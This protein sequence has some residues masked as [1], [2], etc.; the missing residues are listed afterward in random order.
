MTSSGR[1][2]PFCVIV[3]T[4]KNN[5]AVLSAYGLACRI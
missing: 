4:V 5:T 3:R 1:Y 2:Q